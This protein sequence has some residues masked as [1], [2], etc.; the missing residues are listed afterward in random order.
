VQGIIFT[1]L[2]LIVLYVLKRKSPGS[3]KSIGLKGVTS[4]SKMAIGIALPFILLVVG[5]LTSYI[6]CGIDNLSLNITRCV[7]I[8]ILV[9][10]LTAF[11]YEA[12]LEEVFIRG[13]IF[14]DLRNIIRYFIKY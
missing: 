1:G 9:N 7:V 5:I 2:T 14:E 13:I 8:S 3:F 6:F 10:I 11:M 12:F 4:S